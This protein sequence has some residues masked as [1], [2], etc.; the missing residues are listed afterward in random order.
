MHLS[1]MM[2]EDVPPTQGTF[3]DRRALQGS[4]RQNW[5]ESTKTS[6]RFGASDLKEKKEKIKNITRSRKPVNE[7]GGESAS[8]LGS[9]LARGRETCDSKQRV[10]DLLS[11]LA[12][13]RGT[14]EFHVKRGKKNNFNDRDSDEQDIPS[15]IVF[16][17]APSSINF[18]ITGSKFELLERA[19]TESF[20]KFLQTIENEQ[21]EVVYK[22]FAISKMYSKEDL[23][24]I[25][26]FEQKLNAI[27]YFLYVM[28]CAGVYALN[29]AKYDFSDYRVL[30]PLGLGGAG[31]VY[32]T[33]WYFNQ[34]KDSHRGQFTEAY[35]VE[36]SE[37]KEKVET[38]INAI[39]ERFKKYC[40][41]SE[42]GINDRVPTSIT[43]WQQ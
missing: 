34:L 2:P 19:M 29:K 14:K 4:T 21:C 8:D 13:G 26:S 1:A 16:I 39:K 9:N 11:D 42:I 18:D 41:E 25:A 23:K 17:S 6:A 33:T 38:Q 15:P 40:N 37:Q 36:N 24:N 27:K 10:S 43:Y 28:S 32:L 7:G 22:K 35:C 30:I 5:P 3:D 12:K 20:S 31:L